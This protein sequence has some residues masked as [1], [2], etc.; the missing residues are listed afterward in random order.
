MRHRVRS[1]QEEQ[2]QFRPGRVDPPAAAFAGDRFKV[3]LRGEAAERELEALLARELAMARA[4]I[5]AEASEDWDDVVREGGRRFEGVA[6]GDRI[7]AEQN[8]RY[9]NRT[10]DGGQS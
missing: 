10:P 9:A 3:L 2:A 6:G 7:R 1:L 8:A 4:G 5:A